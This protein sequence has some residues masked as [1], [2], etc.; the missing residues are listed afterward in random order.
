M[1]GGETCTQHG[2]PSSINSSIQS[3]NRSTDEQPPLCQL[4]TFYHN[5][6]HT[7]NMIF[8]P[9]A[10]LAAMASLTT[11]TQLSLL[12]FNIGTG[13]LNLGG[14][15]ITGENGLLY[16]IDDGEWQEAENDA[17]RAP[18]SY[19]CGGDNWSDGYKIPELADNVVFVCTDDTCV[20][21]QKYKCTFRYGDIV[22]GPIDSNGD[23]T[24]WGLG[25]AVGTYCGGN[26]VFE[27]TL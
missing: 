16:K 22:A 14:A 3:P 24:Y 27:I 12:A 19:D 10:L 13:T 26:D 23:D 8:Q 15:T 21:G 17:D 2:N 7:P 4:S 20:P 25:N 11:A 5:H 1:K 6:I 9:S 18:C